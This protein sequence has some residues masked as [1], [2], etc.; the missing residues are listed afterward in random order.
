MS[1][2]PEPIH[3]DSNSSRWDL[4]SA[5]GSLENGASRYSGAR[6]PG[7]SLWERVT[8]MSN[9]RSSAISKSVQGPPEDSRMSL[10]S[11]WSGKSPTGRHN[12]HDRASDLTAINSRLSKTS[13]TESTKHSSFSPPTLTDQKGMSTTD[14]PGLHQK[15]DSGYGSMS[16]K[17][18]NPGR[19][20]GDKANS[21]R[22]PHRKSPPQPISIG[23][24]TYVRGPLTQSPTTASPLSR[25]TT[26]ENVDGAGVNSPR[27]FPLSDRTEGD[28]FPTSP[29]TPKFACS[30]NIS[31]RHSSV[32][33]CPKVTSEL[34]S[35]GPGVKTAN[36]VPMQQRRSAG[37]GRMTGSQPVRINGFS[38]KWRDYSCLSSSRSP[39]VS[40]DYTPPLPLSFSN[41]PGA[42]PL[43]TS[44][45]SPSPLPPQKDPARYVKLELPSVPENGGLSDPTSRS[46]Q[47]PS[48]HSMTP[49]LG[50]TKRGRRSGY[51]PYYSPLFDV[52][53]DYLS[54]SPPTSPTSSRQST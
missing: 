11:R 37:T 9:L 52:P 28:G 22:Y 38:E 3:I 7:E 15:T 12:R 40:P 8:F 26:F 17:G 14:S 16:G 33:T 23:E 45:S 19:S 25:R 44:P 47:F 2:G 20:F 42:C 51:H 36:G 13:K 27:K 31:L 4:D 48:T 43:S 39:P 21:R 6:S 10:L 53:K 54:T 1:T 46:S 49:S 30:P 18:F 35:V 32:S 29:Q 5:S 50:T 41:P 34:S 24:P